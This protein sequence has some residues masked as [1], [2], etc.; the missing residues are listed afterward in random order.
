MRL[1][2]VSDWKYRLKPL[3]FPSFLPSFDLFTPTPPLLFFL[4]FFSCLLSGKSA[5]EGT[6][7]YRVV[8]AKIDSYRRYNSECVSESSSNSFS[9][10]NLFDLPTLV[11]CATATH[12]WLLSVRNLSVSWS[13]FAADELPSLY[14]VR[15]HL[16]LLCMCVFCVHTVYVYT[17]TINCELHWIFCFQLWIESKTI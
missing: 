17:P 5:F 6:I 10:L 16:F 8:P 7:L 14:A 1:L 15:M 3:P 12:L 2:N 11:N 9:L 13:Q 4:S